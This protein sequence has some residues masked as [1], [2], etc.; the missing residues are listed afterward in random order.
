MAS[1]RDAL[2]LLAASPLL[3]QNQRFDPEAHEDMEPARRA[4]LSHYEYE[5]ADDI[6]K[7]IFNIELLSGYK[8]PVSVGPFYLRHAL[9][10]EVA[11][12]D[13][14]VN[15]AKSYLY[16]LINSPTQL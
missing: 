3:V 1:K 9:R 15:M 10:N 5:P 8:L 7:A 13:D 12:K 2:K 11:L 16:Y 6:A 4:I 14:I